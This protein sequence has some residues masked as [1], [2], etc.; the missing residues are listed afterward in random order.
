MLVSWSLKFRLSLI[1]AIAEQLCEKALAE[2]SFLLV[3]HTADSCITYS[4]CNTDTVA[5]PCLKLDS[6]AL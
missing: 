1:E 6:V 5:V 4:S 2:V 3:T